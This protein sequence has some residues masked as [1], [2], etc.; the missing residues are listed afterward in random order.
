MKKT[1][2]NTHPTVSAKKRTRPVKKRVSR[3][4]RLQ[5]LLLKVLSE[6][7]GNI[8][9]ACQA[10]KINRSTFYSWRESDPK[11]AEAIDGINEATIDFV[12]SKLLENI[13]DGNVTAQIYFLKTKGRSRGWAEETKQDG[14]DLDRM[15]KLDELTAFLRKSDSLSVA[16]NVITC[17][18]A[19]ND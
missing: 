12:E 9:E 6:N 4:Q 15:R 14:F 1:T 2:K 7:L 8:S 3:Q 18:G 11:F 13:K 16:M 19:E 5:P 10:V 17:A